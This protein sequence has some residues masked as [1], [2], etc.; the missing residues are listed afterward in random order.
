MRAPIYYALTPFLLGITAN[1]IINSG[2]GS[3]LIGI[4]SIVLSIT[5]GRIRK[6]PDFDK[7]NILALSFGGILNIW[8]YHDTVAKENNGVQKIHQSLPPREVVCSIKLS[9][10]RNHIGKYSEYLYLDGVIVNSPKTRRDLVNKTVSA[11][12]RN[13]KCNIKVYK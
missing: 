5:N 1:S 11:M 3:F 8:L 4:I 13:N 7:I 2:Y 6:R 12:L 10:V 9:A